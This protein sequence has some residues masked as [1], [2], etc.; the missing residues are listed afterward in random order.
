MKHQQVSVAFLKNED[1]VFD[2]SD[3]GCVSADTEFLS[4]TGWKRIDCY[5]NEL[6][7]QFHPETREIE[8]VKPIEYIR[9]PCKTMIAIA[10]NRGMSQRLSHEHR[11]LFYRRD[12]SHDVM[13]AAEFMQ[14]LHE[15]GPY[16]ANARFCSTFSVRSSTELDLTDAQIRLMVAVIADGHFG[17]ESTSRCVIRLKKERKIKR[18]KELLILAKTPFSNHPCGGADPDFQVFVFAAPRREKEFTTYWWN[19]SQTQLEIIAD[20]ICYWDS[21]EDS[22]ESNGTRFST[23]IEASANFA[24]YAFAAAKRPAS[25]KFAIR[26]RRAE[27]RDLS[28]EYYV[29][30]QDD[31]K[32]IGPGRTGSVYEVPNTEGFKYCFEVPTSFLLLRHNGYIFATGNTGKTAVHIT[33]FAMRKK[34]LRTY[35][36]ALVLAPKSLLHAAWA[37]DIKK[38]ARHIT[39]SVATATNREAAF[40]AKADVYITNHDAV[41]WL[42]KQPPKFFKRFT[43]LIVDECSAYK[44]H[45]SGRS[46]AVAKI[47]KHF[48]VR[49]M[50]CATPNSNGITDLW[51]QVYLLDN[52]TRLGS[53]FF[54]FRNASC[55]AEQVGRNQH[56]VKWHDRPG[57][58]NIVSALIS[59]I[60]IRHKFEDCVDIPANHMYSVPIQLSTKHQNLYE[61]LKRDSLLI[62]EKG[63]VTAINGAVLYNKLLQAASGTVYDECGAPQY[64]ATDRYEMVLDLAEARPHVVVFFLWA[65]QRDQLV[66]A[67]KSRKLSYCLI[68]GGT[69]DRERQLAVEEFQSGKHRILF[70]HPQSAGHGLT[71]TK[72]TATIWASPTPNLEHFQ[73]GL[74]RIHRIGQT[75][76]TETIMLV[77]EN[78]IDEQVWAALQQKN[79]SMQSLLEELKHA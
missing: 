59:D 15:N 63:N 39:V 47:V 70:A 62:L 29:H 66:A 16:R 52:G 46:R 40:D 12:G 50:L 77:A 51:H 30:A 21:S 26:D 9:R 13:S 32:F 23:H 41:A 4:P 18:L 69:S 25:L 27:D 36:A 71:L 64:L 17:A 38:F 10:P 56:A 44:H 42:A 34:R 54:G 73:Q 68:D 45:T 55:V 72:G 24:Q 61:Q 75:E 37:A 31:D 3:P 76:K 35:G 79:I 43:H 74:K 58:E 8:F 67:A 53:T 6:V 33:D 20:E 11:V 5:D 1:R 60:T 57:I 19:A 28:V 65:H 22:R 2:M 78:T 48:D 7:A 14:N 49:R